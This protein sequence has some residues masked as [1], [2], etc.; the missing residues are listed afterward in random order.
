MGRME[1]KMTREELED[2]AVDRLCQL[3]YMEEVGREFAQYLKVDR[4]SKKD[5]KRK[6]KEAKRKARA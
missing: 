2:R 3:P 4:P 6:R 1:R 5:L